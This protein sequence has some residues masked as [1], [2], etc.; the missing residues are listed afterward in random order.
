MWLITTEI[1]FFQMRC[2]IDAVEWIDSIKEMRQYAW[3]KSYC[4]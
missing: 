3:Q 2:V 1:R 4:N